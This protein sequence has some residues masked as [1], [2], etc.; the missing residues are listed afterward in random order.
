MLDSSTA[1]YHRS[2]A[3][4]I[5]G[6]AK[7]TNSRTMRRFLAEIGLTDNLLV[8]SFAFNEG[9]SPRQLD[10]LHRFALEQIPAVQAEVELV[11]LCETTAII[12]ASFG[13]V[14]NVYALPFS[15]ASASVAQMQS[16]VCLAAA[17]ALP[18]AEMGRSSAAVVA[19][20]ADYRYRGLP[21]SIAPD[22]LLWTVAGCD[23][24]G[25]SGV[26]EWCFDEA[27]AQAVLSEMRR[28]PHR[29]S[30]LVAEPFSKA[31]QETVSA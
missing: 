27:D 16:A 6:G 24:R 26:L 20:F 18:L 10:A 13:S 15:V 30:G 4:S 21:C 19:G 1:S 17:L 5:L 22:H 8:Q 2:R 31:Q 9:Y 7:C 29:F 25:G 14:A 11:A 28:F 3:L 12:D 23:K